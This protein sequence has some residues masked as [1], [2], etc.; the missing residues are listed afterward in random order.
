MV[1][2]QIH[3]LVDRRIGGLENID[4]CDK[5][6]IYVDRRIGGLERSGSAWGKGII[7]DRRIGGLEILF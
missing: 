1:V 5:G 4:K 3:H 7:V 2:Y 6:S